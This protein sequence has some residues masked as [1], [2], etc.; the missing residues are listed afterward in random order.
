M[1]NS[2]LTQA[3]AVIN[4]GIDGFN[5]S[6]TASGGSLASIDWQP[7][8]NA[9]P[10]LAWQ[11]AQ[12]MG[13]ERI[14]AANAEACKRIINARPM[15]EDMA[16]RADGV[17]PELKDSRVLLHAGPPVSWRDM[18]G[19]M[20]G[21][22][23]GAVLYEGWA[24]TEAEAAQMLK[25]GQ[26]DF[27]QCHDF[28]SV[29]P[30]TGIISASMPLIQVRNTS[31]GNVAYCTLNE[32]IGKC[33]RFGANGPEV[34]AR[35]KWFE[36]VLAPVLKAAVQHN[37]DTTG[38]IDLK[39]IQSQALLMGDEVHSRNAASTALFFMAVAPALA[40]Q[41]H[42]NSDHVRQTLDFIAK[43]SQFFLNYSMASCKAIMD[44]AHGIAFST[45]V[46]ATARNGTETGLRV[47]GMGREW[48]TAKSDLPKGLFFPG[49]KQEDACP[50]IG[51]SAITETA[52]FGG[53]SFAASPALTLLAG[54]T[55]ED[56]VRYSREMYEI[57]VT[58][59]PA[60]SLPALDFAG[61]P[62]GIDVRKVVD[63]GIRPVVTTGIAHKEAGVGQIGAGIVR[64][65]M[66]AYSKALMGIA[67]KYN[68]FVTA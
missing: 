35:L 56:A 7:P 14:E 55:V 5:A 32:G 42:L 13:D 3:P 50:D 68:P 18:C 25:S 47:S 60:L 61:A 21:A 19:P 63:T 34:I 62:C 15:W 1:K 57:T 58:K 53:C 33:M 2:L 28:N 31:Y 10:A 20:H 26:I 29:G 51:D 43:N 16:L 36:A 30:M 66:E 67:E 38:G 46:T 44:A 17:I 8:G 4:I 22:M 48:F 11:L 39:A 27:A 23:V 49:F 64:V 54:G 37:V 6:V 9:D 40:A 52:G 12:L 59:N 45:V 41:P 24:S 65:P